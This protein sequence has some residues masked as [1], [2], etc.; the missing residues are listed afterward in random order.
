MR[1]R[2]LSALAGASM[3]TIGAVG[4]ASAASVQPKFHEGNA[5]VDGTYAVDCPGGSKALGVDGDK[6]SGGLGGVTVHIT[7]H[8]DNSID[9]SA[10]GG[11]VAVAFVK[12]G[13]DANEYDYAPPVSSDWNLVSPLVGNDKNVP[14]V[15]HTVFC[16]TEDE[17][18]P[19]E[20]PSEEPSTAPSEEPSTAPSEE[21]SEEPSTAPSEEPSTEPSEE[22]SEEPSTAPSEEPSTAPSEEPSTEPS[23]QP[24]EEPSTAPSE[25]ASTE[26]SESPDG[27][28]EAETDV[29]SA[30]P[31]DVS[32]TTG[33]GTNDVL[34]V[35]FLVFGLIGIGAVAL[36][37][38]RNRR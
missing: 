29:P 13:P 4:I 28:V 3:L 27:G 34:P 33:G 31:T 32:G 26:P 38:A 14:D 7:Y 30:P 24:S 37:P 5:T 25:E 23:E 6:T 20:Q 16:V 12:G 10:T 15:S 19:S 1:L 8:D 11:K 36:T 9:F 18:G 17:E 22:P 35:L 21:P 2:R